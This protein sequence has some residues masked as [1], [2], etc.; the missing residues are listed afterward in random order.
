MDFV[1]EWADAPDR[2]V[3]RDCSLFPGDEEPDG[4]IMYFDGAFARQGAGSEVI[5]ISL[6]KDKL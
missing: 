5:L 2:G 6:A 1:V 3:G 4:W